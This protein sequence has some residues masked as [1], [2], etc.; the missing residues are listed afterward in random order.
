MAPLQ[1]RAL[2]GLIFGIL[3]AVAIIVIFILMGGVTAYDEDITFRSIVIGVWIGGLIAYLILFETV[4]K[5]PEKVDERDRLVITQAGTTQWWAVIFTLVIWV[6]SLS[7]IYHEQGQV[8]VIFLYLI[9]I[10]IL[11]VSMIA[12]SLGILIGY[13]RINHNG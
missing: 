13:W 8:P 7:E 1:K 5:K 4:R 6:I 10:S 9:F 3:W 2:Y 11:I 12:Q